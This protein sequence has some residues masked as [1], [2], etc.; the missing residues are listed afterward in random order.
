MELSR[1]RRL[2]GG[3]PGAAVHRTGRAVEEELV[4]DEL[5]ADLA[6]G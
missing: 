6:P 5:L 1:L 2:L 3:Q 4:L